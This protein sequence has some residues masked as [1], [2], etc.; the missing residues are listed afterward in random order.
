MTIIPLA[1][2][3]FDSLSK[4]NFFLVEDHRLSVSG[5]RYYRFVPSWVTK[6]W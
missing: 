4:E 3:M 5:F 1:L 6:S 2:D